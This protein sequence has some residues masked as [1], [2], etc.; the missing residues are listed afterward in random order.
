MS[1]SLKPYIAQ[2]IPITLSVNSAIP[3]RFNIVTLVLLQMQLLR[4][5]GEI[6]RRFKGPFCLLLQ[7]HAKSPGKTYRLCSLL[8][9]LDPKVEGNMTF[10]NIET[11]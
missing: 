5:L 4:A 9:L 8:Q 10:R 11:N 6:L 1:T 7:A 2:F 3:A